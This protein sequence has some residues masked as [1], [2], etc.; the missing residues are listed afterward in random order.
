MSGTDAHVILDDRLTIVAAS[1]QAASLLDTPPGSLIGR[2]CR[3][4]LGCCQQMGMD[5]PVQSALADPPVATGPVTTCTRGSGIRVLVTVQ[6]LWDQDP[7]V[8]RAM[9]TLREATTDADLVSAL[10][11][12]LLPLDAVENNLK[13]VLGSLR[14]L[15]GS[16]LAALARYD[17]E[18]REVHWQL[19]SG[20][21]CSSVT[22]IR[23][24]PG[25]GFAGRIVSSLRPL[26]TRS[27]PA[28]L[29]PDPS[30]YPILLREEVCSAL[31]VPLM[32]GGQPVGVLMIGSRSPRSYDDEDLR[33]LNTVAGV[34][35]LAASN[36]WLFRDAYR[37]AATQERERLAG[38]VHDGLSQQFFGLQM[39][40]TS[41]QQAL[42]SGDVAGLQEGLG[43]M[44]RMLDSSLVEVRSLISRLRGEANEPPGLVVAL[45]DYLEYYGRMSGI[46][47]ELSLQIPLGTEIQFPQEQEI[48]RVAQEALMNVYRHAGARR[49]Q[50]RL[51]AEGDG[52][53]LSIVDDGAGFD[54]QAPQASGHYGLQIMRERAGR[55]G[56]SLDVR[57]APGTGTE[58][59]LWFSPHRMN[60]SI[61]QAGTG[62]SGAN[63]TIMRD[64]S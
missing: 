32:V 64:A 55:T 33:I 1:S 43:D 53:R 42:T 45:C 9:V 46:E 17:R 18:H 12:Q 63:V 48:V 16:D 20:N 30:S 29:T 14:L 47:V 60:S 21:Q 49:V 15:L 54:S 35:S 19:A 39:V 40:L 61:A 6:P 50:V 7:S 4:T 41:V 59:T 5:C 58:V 31:G 11:Q 37:R 62:I 10:S 23:L 8:R 24:R 56:S 51:V 3:A 25:Q 44:R 38:E 52:Y 13:Q 57:S 27:F 34:M 26:Q 22:D 36:V 28:D 2:S